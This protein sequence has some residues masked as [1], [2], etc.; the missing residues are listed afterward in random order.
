MR[1]TLSTL[2]LLCAVVSSSATNGSFDDTHKYRRQSSASITEK[3]LMTKGTLINTPFNRETVS[4]SPSKANAKAPAMNGT[5]LYFA[6]PETSDFNK[7]TIID[8]NHD[9]CTW[10][11]PGLYGMS[12]SGGRA[13]LQADDWCILPAIDMDDASVFYNFY[14]DARGAMDANPEDF[15]VFIGTSPDIASMTTKILEVR[16][17]D[18]KRNMNLYDKFE[19]NFIIPASGTYYIGFHAISPGTSCAF[20]VRNIYLTK[21]AIKSD[22]PAQVSD[23]SVEGNTHGGLT[24]TVSFKMPTANNL[25]V[26]YAAD[27]NISVRIVT[28]VE[29]KTVTGVAGSDQSVVVKTQE[30]DNDIIITTIDG[31]NEGLPYLTSVNTGLD[32]PGSPENIQASVSENNM[33]L[34]LKWDAPSVGAN[35]GFVDPD[36]MDYYI[37]KYSEDQETWTYMDFTNGATEYS[38]SV[39]PS[40]GQQNMILGVAAVNVK[41]EETPEK[42]YA[43]ASGVI[44][45]PY[46]TPFVEE[47]RIGAERH[48]PVVKDIPSADYDTYLWYGT[49]ALGL[50]SYADLPGRNCY[51]AFSRQSGKTSY[52]RTVLPKIS[53]KNLTE[54]QASFYIFINYETPKTQFYITDFSGNETLLGQIDKNSGSGGWTMFTYD[55]P[56]EY[57]GQN[58]VNFVIKGE[59]DNGWGQ[60]MTLAGYELTAVVDHDLAIS[61]MRGEKALTSE[62]TGYYTAIVENR[63]RN[64]ETLQL[65]AEVLDANEN[66]LS[67]LNLM[68]NSD[69]MTIAKG[70]RAEYHWQ[71]APTDEHQGDVTL[72]VTILNDDQRDDNNVMDYA[73]SVNKALRPE[74]DEFSLS[75]EDGNI[76]LNW[77]TPVIHFHDSFEEYEPFSYDDYLGY[78]LNYDED[79]IATFTFNGLSSFPGSEAAKAWQ[80]FSVSKSGIIG[81]NYVAPDGDQYLIAFGPADSSAASD[82]LLSPMIKGGS[83][84]SFKMN[85]VGDYDE[86]LDIVYAVKDAPELSDFRVLDGITKKTFG[87][88]EY[89]Y[90]LPSNATYWGLH[91]VSADCFGVMIDELD[92]KV[93][94][95]RDIL[96]YNI[97]RNGNRIASDVKGFSFTDP[98]GRKSDRYSMAVSYMNA[99]KVKTEG[100]MSDELYLAESGVSSIVASSNILKVEYTTPAGVKVGKPAN[101][102]FIRT[103]YYNDGTVVTDKIV[104]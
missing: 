19:K 88:E 46:S 3:G 18:Y 8:N 9:G 40:A 10:E 12:Y 6:Y 48:D 36:N 102:V 62:E 70:E 2:A 60:F 71:Y 75:A 14:C 13:T 24:A 41:N 94:F 61:A 65:K 20:Y 67:T 23:V 30:G 22:S 99:S 11:A 31:S 77:G 57:L 72:R 87:W 50:G 78:L 35:G 49:P 69:S 98:D 53:T 54:G 90:R 25:G 17:L 63:G 74:V 80:V 33:R 37:Y 29:K 100:K 96:G 81:S 32:V 34:T 43:I 28:P 42:L 93:D 58:W 92:Y 16:D 84:V 82:W 104:K 95:N 59:Y 86:Y 101:G 83:D 15:D 39:K 21:T 7:Y 64:T 51:I 68:S 97:Y 55:I 45:Q 38:T 79:G 73:I 56:A 52:S 103:T 27:K 4:K 85:I 47:F 44:G 89:S 91:Y 66:V 76:I 5:Q 1:Q 26:A